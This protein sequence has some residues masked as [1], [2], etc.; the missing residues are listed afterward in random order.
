M[1]RETLLLAFRFVLLVLIQTLILNN[2]YF[3]GYINPNLYILFIFLYPIEIKRTNFL[4]ISFLFGLTID[5]F[6]NTGGINAAA[7]VAI[8]YIRFPLLKL[9]LNSQDIDF[10]LF[11]LNQ[12]P[13]LRIFT[14]VS[15]LTFVHHFILIGLEYFNLSEFGNIAY[16]TF[17]TSLFTIFLCMLA[18]YLSKKSNKSNL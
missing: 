14:F 7:T 9:L 17:T 12:E 13:F 5:I 1:T 6:S 3:F 10:K 18:I 8:A 15:I 4:L 2:I 11:K 16:K